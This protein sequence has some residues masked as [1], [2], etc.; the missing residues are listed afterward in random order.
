MHIRSWFY[1]SGGFL[2]K[3]TLH[4]IHFVGNVWVL[5]CGNARQEVDLGGVP[6]RRTC[7]GGHHKMSVP[8]EFGEWGGE[9]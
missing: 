9:G 5:Y 2:S 6:V 4:Y 8:V 3:S 1:Q 7:Y